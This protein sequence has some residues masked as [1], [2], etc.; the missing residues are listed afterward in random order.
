MVEDS[1]HEDPRPMGAWM[2][3][4]VVVGGRALVNDE[5]S[6]AGK[7][8]TGRLRCLEDAGCT[9]KNARGRKKA[10]VER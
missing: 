7:E 5:G 4:G 2:A 9:E 8:E 1:D 3:S 6:G 10:R